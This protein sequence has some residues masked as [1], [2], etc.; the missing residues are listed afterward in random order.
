MEVFDRYLFKNLAL[1]TI[2]VAAT[3]AAAILLTQSLRFLELV[4]ESGASGGAFWM[5]TLLALPRF[6]EI[7]LPIA[8]MA[9]VVF[10]YNKMTMDSELVV[11]RALGRPPLRLARPAIILSGGVALFLLLMTTWAAPVS[12]TSMQ[13]MRQVIKAQYSTLLFRAGVFNDV[14]PGLTVFVRER[15]AAGE[16]RGL[17][18]HDSRDPEAQPVTILAKRGL[19]LITPEGQQ[20]K[21]YDGSRQDLNPTTNALNRLDFESYTIDLPEGGGPVRQRWREPEERTLF[22]LFRP[23]MQN[24][25]DVQNRREFMVEI[26]RR[27]VAPLLAPAL[28]MLSLAFLLV[29]PV[30]RRGQSWRILLTI[31]MAVTIQGLYLGA[32]SLAQQSF[33]GLLLM[34]ALVLVPLAG[35]W[36]MLSAHSEM[37]RYRVQQKWGRLA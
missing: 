7:I 16:L 19:I 32:F 27:L 6:F 13:Q 20:V 31:G 12:L 9:A 17:M 21:V 3:L 34:Y 24:Q 30:D 11:M 23:D 15:S 37:L 10:V 28:A 22:E 35:G 14:V 33:V 29:G 26:H 2:F 25:N 1:A 4:L 18:I 8:L 36:F 5:L